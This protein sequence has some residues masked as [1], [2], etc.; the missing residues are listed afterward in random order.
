MSKQFTLREAK[1]RLSEILDLAAAGVAVEITRQGAKRGRFKL[2]PA[3][4][5]FGKRM[6]G[7]LKGKI[8]IPDDFD[9]EDPEIVADFE[10]HT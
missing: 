4:A 6:P 1:A 8:F 9:K 7:A 2:I 3:D 5:E 10:G